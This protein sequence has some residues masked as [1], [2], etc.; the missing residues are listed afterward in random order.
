MGP[1]ESQ[2]IVAKFGGTSMKDKVAMLRSAQ[3][4][5]QRG[6]CLI[7]VSA[8]SGTTNLLIQLLKA[9]ENGDS[10]EKRSILESIVSKHQSLAD[11]LSISS[12]SN[13]LLDQLFEELKTLSEGTLLLRDCS[14]KTYD[15]IVSIGERMSSVLFTEALSQV[16]EEKKSNK[17]AALIDVRELMAT[18]DHHRH[19]KPHF[20]AIEQNCQKLMSKNIF[21]TSLLVTQGFMGQAPDG[22]TTTLGRGGS[23]YSAAL[24]AWGLKAD[25]LEIWT[26]VAGIATTDPRIC[27]AAQVIPE[28]SFQEASEL[29]VFGAKILH[30]TTLAPAIQKNIP[31][32]VGSSYEPEKGG[33]WIVSSLKEQQKTPLIRAMALRKAQTLITLT[34]PKMLQAHGFLYQI[35]KIFNKY[36]VS[37]DAITTSEISV[38]LTLNPEDAQNK[39]LI[40]ELEKHAQ[41]KIES[42][43]ELVSLIGNQINHTPGLGEKIFSA[44]QGINVRMTCHGASKHNFCFLVEQDQGEM[45][46]KK[47]HQIFIEAP[48]NNHVDTLSEAL[49]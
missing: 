22:T 7:V 3:I 16:L 46:I 40:F 35:F 32:Y 10:A 48:L 1:R 42:N 5:V 13:T 29:A 21:E 47:L 37:V 44:I 23:D 6:A 27:P 17:S 8:T 12:N 26:D 34:T 20:E 4:S 41:V 24:L 18:D 49:V 33:T 28:I 36:E 43:L 9:A 2:R 11:D 25:A 19:A 39:A 31:V 38:A 45:A 30:P 14:D 15:R